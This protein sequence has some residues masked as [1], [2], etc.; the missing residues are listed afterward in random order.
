MKISKTPNFIVFIQFSGSFFVF[1]KKLLRT[2]KNDFFR[3]LTKRNSR[4]VEIL[5]ETFGVL[6]LAEKVIT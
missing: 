3:I 1:L 5:D 4:S 6:L 2:E